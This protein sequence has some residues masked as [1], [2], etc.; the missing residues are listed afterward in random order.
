MTTKMKIF[1][2]ENKLIFFTKT[3]TTT[4]NSP[5]FVDEMKTKTK[6]QLTDEDDD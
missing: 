5:V 6:I 4:E 2:D 3:M 1:V